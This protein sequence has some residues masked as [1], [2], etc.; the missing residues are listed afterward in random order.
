MKRTFLNFEMDNSRAASEA[1]KALRANVQFCGTDVHAIVITSCLP[2][3][4]KSTTSMGLSLALARAGKKVLLVDADLR[5]SVMARKYSDEV[6]VMGFSELL[7][8]Q[9]SL[10]DVIYATQEENMKIVFSG[11]YPANPAELLSS[12]ALKLFV[13]EQKSN[14]DY[15]IIDTPPLGVVVDAAVVA[16]VC[17]SAILV[18]AEGKIKGDFAIG[19]K[20]QLE[21]SGVHII[22]VVLNANDKKCKGAIKYRGKYS[23]KYYGK[24]YGKYAEE[25][26]AK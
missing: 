3:D 9:A 18:V 7:S 10:D 11:Q 16:N 20:E 22:G 5:K 23:G 15:I 12:S 1:F 19:V 4:G 25:Y 13:E 2:D 8:G 17:D 24:H 14:Y 26:K 6:G 21:K